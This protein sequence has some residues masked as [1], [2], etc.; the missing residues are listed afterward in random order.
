ML[1]TCMGTD[2]STK[3]YPMQ[4]QTHH[5]YH[6]QNGGS[7]GGGGGGLMSHAGGGSTKEIYDNGDIFSAKKAD[8]FREALADVFPEDIP[9]LPRHRPG[10]FSPRYFDLPPPPPQQQQQQTLNYSDQA[11]G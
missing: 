1:R 6:Q 11:V 3:E 4:Q 7:N 2:A 10:Q 5:N 8:E 9:G